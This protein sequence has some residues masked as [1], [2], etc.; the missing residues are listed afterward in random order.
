[1]DLAGKVDFCWEIRS[2]CLLST[3]IA[4]LQLCK[5]SRNSWARFHQHWAPNRVVHN[6]EDSILWWSTPSYL[7]YLHVLGPAFLQTTPPLPRVVTQCTW[8]PSLQLRMYL[9]CVYP[10]IPS[11]YTSMLHRVPAWQQLWCPQLTWLALRHYFP[12]LQD[13]HQ[14][15]D[16]L[17]KNHIPLSF[18]HTHLYNFS[19]C[20][21]SWRLS[22]VQYPVQPCSQ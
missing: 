2:L 5:H 15:T 19:R 20:W 1:M 22:K 6:H 11:T 18:E 13:R 10:L 9:K 7:I 21:K 8:R 12:F 4:Y 16:Q 14:S 3:S 17:H